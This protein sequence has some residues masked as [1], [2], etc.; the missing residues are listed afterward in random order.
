MIYD[1]CIKVCANGFMITQI[2]E[3]YE[4]GEYVSAD[5]VFVEAEE[6]LNHVKR[7]L[8]IPLSEVK[9]D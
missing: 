8:A 7:F 5:E 9:S 1:Y 3:D 4:T 2:Y 6:V